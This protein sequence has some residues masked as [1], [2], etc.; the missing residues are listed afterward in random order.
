MELPFKKNSFDI[1]AM[2]EVLEHLPKG[3]ELFAFMEINRV[4][5]KDGVLLLSTPYADYRARYLDPFWYFGHRHYTKEKI[6]W[7]LDEGGFF[8]YTIETS[9]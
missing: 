6:N 8:H 9:G 3:E 1:V 5:R 4:L 7:F 2:W